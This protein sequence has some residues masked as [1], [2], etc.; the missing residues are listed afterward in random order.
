MS[1]H[2]H[3]HSHA[4]HDH[5]HDHGHGHAHDD[6]EVKYR[7]IYFWLVGLLGLSIV[8]PFV[9]QATKIWILTLITAF[10]VAIVKAYLV[11]KNFMHLNLEPRFVA[12][13][14]GVALAFMTLLFFFVGPDVMEH[15]GRNWSNEAAKAAVAAGGPVHGHGRE[16]D[17][18]HE[19]PTGG[20][21]AH[22]V[23]APPRFVAPPPRP[24]PA[25]QA[26]AEPVGAEPSAVAAPPAPPA[27]DVEYENQYRGRFI[28]DRLT[29]H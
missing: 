4:A 5:S 27:A 25:P 21:P 26:V 29:G 19:E 7:K 24:E 3:D 15:E 12:Y 11:V 2:A 1:E 8:G 20:E 14:S 16:S 23:P 6:H 10:G 18:H 17:G 9:G 22:V 28:A 13:I